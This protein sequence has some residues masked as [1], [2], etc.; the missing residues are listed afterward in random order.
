MYKVS[1]GMARWWNEEETRENTRHRF[2]RDE[3]KAWDF[4]DRLNKFPSSLIAWNDLHKRNV[5]N[6][7]I[8]YKQVDTR[9]EPK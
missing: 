9:G 5:I 4:L 8:T 1:F 6:G 2:F 3:K 7:K